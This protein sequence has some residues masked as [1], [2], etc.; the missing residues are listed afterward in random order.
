MFGLPTYHWASNPLSI[1]LQH[2][3]PDF[4]N[5]SF[6]PIWLFG[7]KDIARVGSVNCGSSENSSNDQIP[8]H[9][10]VTGKLR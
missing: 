4:T 9:G 8:F 10:P 7:W 5:S 3:A 6:G 2:V 1:P